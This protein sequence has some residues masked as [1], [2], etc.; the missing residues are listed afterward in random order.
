MERA[1]EPKMTAEAGNI[2]MQQLQIF[3][4]QLE[5][6]QQQQKALEAAFNELSL[7]VENQQAA[8]AS[9]TIAAAA[10]AAGREGRG[11]S[12][13]G[14][15]SSFKKLQSYIKL[16]LFHGRADED[17]L[18]FLLALERIKQTHNIPD[19]QMKEILGY[20]LE[21]TAKTIFENILTSQPDLGFFDMGMEIRKSFS[22]LNHGVI[23]RY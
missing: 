17:V 4:Q 5:Q 11:S 10:V 12:S 19:K 8:S 21:G 18:S 22:P 23:Y 14:T 16:P 20:Q 13:G 1:E 9:L 2:L 15:I 3:Q 6:H 7:K